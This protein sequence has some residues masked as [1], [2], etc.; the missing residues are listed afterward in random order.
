MEERPTDLLVRPLL[1]GE[2][3]IASDLVMR[4]YRVAR[5]TDDTPKGVEEFTRYASAG[6]INARIGAGSIA[7]IACYGT[8]PVGIVEIRSPGHIGLLFIVSEFQ[9]RGVGRA[10]CE[11]AL[12]AFA[13]AHTLPPKL[14]VKSSPGAVAFYEK[15]GFLVAGQMTEFNGIRF[16]P[17]ERELGV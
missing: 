2:E 4:A 13:R 14:T 10:L 16:V 8:L 12:A 11:A 7:L 9:G 3:A 1:S 5:T 15:V 6:S 17:M